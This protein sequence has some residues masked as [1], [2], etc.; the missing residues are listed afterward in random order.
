[1]VFTAHHLN[2]QPQEHLELLL[3]WLTL[4]IQVFLIVFVFFS[5][6]KK[7]Q[8]CKETECLASDAWTNERH[9]KLFQQIWLPVK[10]VALLSRQKDPRYR[11]IYM[12]STAST[13]RHVS[14][15]IGPFLRRDSLQKTCKENHSDLVD[16]STIR[17]ETK[18]VYRIK[19][20]RHRTSN[21]VLQSSLYSEKSEQL[22]KFIFLQCT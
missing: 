22:C 7:P 20:T 4:S 1:M 16:K 8:G 6:T 21:L 2:L 17:F 18:F 5:T 11:G 9:P 3:L 13:K 14:S 12:H 19:T 10:E 15:A